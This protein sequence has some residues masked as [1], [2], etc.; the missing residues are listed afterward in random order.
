MDMADEFLTIGAFARAARLSP[1]ALRLYD[2]CGLLRPAA[3][4]T[5]SGYRYYAP[6][7][8][9]RARL[10]AWL[11]RIDMPLARIREVCDLPGAELAAA[12]GEHMDRAEAE[13]VARRRLAGFLTDHLTGKGTTMSDTAT[14]GLRFAAGSEIGQVRETQQDLAYAGST[15]LAVA[16]GSG[17]AGD[18]AAAAAVDVFRN[19]KV[20]GDL[21]TTL[22][23]AVRDADAA[24]LALGAGGEDRPI[25]TLTA[26]LWS[27]TR[28][29]V[30]HIG[31]TRAY[32]VRGGELSRFTDDHTYV[33]G[34]VD[35]GKLSAEAARTHP[36]RPL[37]VRALGADSE[38]DLAIRTA[39][40]DD[41][42]LLCSDGLWAVVPAERIAAVLTAGH[43]P[44]ETVRLLIE[45]A[46]GAGGPDNIACVVADVVPV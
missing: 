12:I 21:L 4:D 43:D 37:L 9:D 35:A 25:T 30:T 10:V 11:R 16:D 14:L 23:A 24:V 19:L 29:G 41:R 20:T 7:Q 31:D 2:D 36:K 5:D 33:Q 17:P 22:A 26:L 15:L 40:Q 13:F 8:L 1:K 27:G 32:L 3:V 44:G 45:L 42:Y 46:M 38:A 18:R 28:I 6:G 34:L 39:V